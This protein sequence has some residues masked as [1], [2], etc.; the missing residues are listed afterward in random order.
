MKLVKRNFGWNFENVAEFH[1][2]QSG[3]LQTASSSLQCDEL[4]KTKI[5]CKQIIEGNFHSATI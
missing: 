1:F 3:F 5:I 2:Q 4:N